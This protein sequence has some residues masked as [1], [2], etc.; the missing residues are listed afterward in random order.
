M[1]WQMLVSALAAAAG[2]TTAAPVQTTEPTIEI[3][4][5]TG[6]TYDRMTVPVTIQGTGPY[7]FMID[8]GA[9]ATV[10][11]IDVASRVQVTNRRTA[12]LV[13]M[14]SQ[15]TV[16]TVSVDGLGLGSRLFNVATAPLIE[17]AKLAGADG[18]LGLDSLQDQRVLIDFRKN[19]IHVAN[20]K[21]L[22][23][24]S[25]YEI[26][27]RAKR[28]LGQLIITQAELD[29]FKVAVI[30]D[31]GAQGSSGNMALARKLRR[32]QGVGTAVMTDINGISMAGTMRLGQ[33]L[34]LERA[35]LQN[36]AIL[37]I[38]SP[39]FKSLGLEDE[40][41][42]VLG[43]EQLRLFDRVAIDFK[44]Q[45]VL[46]DLPSSAAFTAVAFNSRD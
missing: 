15:R 7:D 17:A 28:K 34:S 39:I 13:G 32:K 4:E 14:A 36:L 43:M 26:V 42:L 5:V 10:M 37:F 29:G 33:S 41:A 1:A 6:G 45:K 12:L 2:L 30:I 38:D 25:G 16:E 8:T 24:N 27:V 18:V 19:E 3:V 46:F 20:A 11:S 21:Q 31:T 44:T 9:Q 35:Q 22:G 40:P 23:G